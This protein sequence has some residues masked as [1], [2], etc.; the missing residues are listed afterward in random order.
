MHVVSVVNTCTKRI[1]TKIC[2]Y[3]TEQCV[4]ADVPAKG[5][6]DATLGVFPAMSSFRYEYKEKTTPCPLGLSC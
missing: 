5:R 6:K 4:E 3:K 2:Y 1:V